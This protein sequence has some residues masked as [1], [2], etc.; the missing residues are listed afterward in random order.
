MEGVQ[1]QGLVHGQRVVLEDADADQCTDYFIVNGALS[2]HLPSR[3]LTLA[4]RLADHGQGRF[5]AGQLS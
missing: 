3:K 2:N 4:K 5:L 1:G